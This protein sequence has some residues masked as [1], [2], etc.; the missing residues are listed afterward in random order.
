MARVAPQSTE[1]LAVRIYPYAESSAV[2]V[3]LTRDLGLA[4]A[5][6]KGAKRTSNGYRGPLD[7][8]I[9]YAVRLSRRGKEGLFHLTTASVR[10]AFPRLRESA[11]RF[12]AASFV[13]EVAADLMRENEPHNELFRLTAFTLKALD[14]A[15]DDRIGLAAAFFLARA[16]ALSGHKPEITCCVACGEPLAPDERPLL[17]PLR[18]GVLH[19]ACGAGEP[20]ARLVTPELV[21]LLAVLWRHP[22]GSVLTMKV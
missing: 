4:R 5:V 1:A 6:A 17:G 21:E 2:V 3:T 22:A 12:F 7:K 14:R 20:G 10:E 11:P 18:G 8:C 15:P 13:L 9:L 16:V 19:P